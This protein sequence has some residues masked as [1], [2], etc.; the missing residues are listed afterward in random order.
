MPKFERLTPTDIAKKVS[1]PPDKVASILKDPYRLG[2]F[3]NKDGMYYEIS[4]PLFRIYL[5]WVS[6]IQ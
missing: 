5:R 1:I 2:T 6:G 4:E 3:I